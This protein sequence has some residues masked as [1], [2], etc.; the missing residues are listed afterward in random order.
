AVIEATLPDG[1]VITVRGVGVSYGIGANLSE[2]D[3]QLKAH[4]T[5]RQQAGLRAARG[6][7]PPGT[8]RRGGR[9]GPV[10]AEGREV[11][12]Q[13]AAAAEP[14]EA[15]PQVTLS[16]ELATDPQ[17]RTPEFRRWFG[18]S[19]VVDAQ[20]RP[21]VVYHGT[22]SNITAFEPG[23]DGA[24]YFT[25]S[26]EDASAFAG[27]FRGLTAERQSYELGG[28]NVIPAFLSIRNPLEHDFGGDLFDPDSVERVIRRARREG[29]D[30]VIIRNIQNFEGGDTSTTYIAFQPEQIKSA[31]GNV[32]TF[33]PSSPD[34]LAQEA[35]APEQEAET[36][37]QVPATDIPETIEVDGVERPTR[38]SNG[39]LIHPT[40]EGIRNFWRWFGDSEVVDEQ[41]RPLVMYH[42]T[43]ADFESFATSGVKRTTSDPNTRLGIHFAKHPSV[44]SQFAE[45]EGGRV[46]PVYLSLQN[47]LR[48]S[49]ETDLN[50][51]MARFAYEN[52]LL[53]VDAL[54]AIGSRDALETARELENKEYERIADKDLFWYGV[55]TDVTRHAKNRMRIA[56]AYQKH[57]E[58]LGYDGIEYG[59]TV[60]GFFGNTAYNAFRPEQIKSATGNVGTFDPASPN[61]TQLEGVEVE[62]RSLDELSPE[63]RRAV[64]MFRESMEHFER[65][66]QPRIE[67][68]GRFEREMLENSRRAGREYAEQRGFTTVVDARFRGAKNA[69]QIVYI[70]DLAGLD[71]DARRRL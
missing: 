23:R 17:T 24:I 56:R 54:R 65:E 40:V 16:E 20:G 42:G 31:I 5:A 8:T 51:A 68:Q 39:Q 13:L 21:L 19:K 1:E 47:P 43:T 11:E 6:E 3:T 66:V 59:N 52:G 64:E 2:A 28:A 57:L 41:G 14:A 18:D 26:P 12:D 50:A 71:A 44:A 15:G 53:T 62:E 63:D 29:H 30:G 38:N 10:E 55:G 49:L 22:R 69:P 4:K 48:F 32:G 35:R 27:D 9:R 67:E 34:I 45:A 60:E 7:E 61:I 70:E 33:D 25:D 58:K 36:F 46:I 37:E